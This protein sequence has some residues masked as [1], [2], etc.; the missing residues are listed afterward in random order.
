MRATE[1]CSFC[2]ARQLPTT[3]LHSRTGGLAFQ[4]WSLISENGISDAQ[5]L[6]L[7]RVLYRCRCHCSAAQASITGPGDSGTGPQTLPAR[8]RRLCGNAGAHSPLAQRPEVHLAESWRRSAVSAL[9]S[10]SCTERTENSEAA[11]AASANRKCERYL[12][13]LS[14]RLSNFSSGRTTGK[15]ALDGLIVS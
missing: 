10:L 6:H 11:K 4:R 13:G 8:G 5:H 14:R 1:S 12:V 15:P 2:R 9:R 7:S 3:L